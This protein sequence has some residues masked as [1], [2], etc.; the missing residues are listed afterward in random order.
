MAKVAYVIS[1]HF[2]TAGVI[3]DQWKP[4]LDGCDVYVSV[5]DYLGKWNA[6]PGVAG[7][8]CH[9]KRHVVTDAMV[10]EVFPNATVQIERYDLLEPLFDTQSRL[11]RDWQ[12]SLGWKFASFRCLSYL[13][14]YYRRQ[15]GYQLLE[16]TGKSYDV[17]VLTRP[18]VLIEHRIESCP[19]NVVLSAPNSVPDPT[20][21]LWINDIVLASEQSIAKYISTIYSRY[22][23]IFHTAKET[24]SPQSFFDPHALIKHELDVQKVSMQETIRAQITRPTEE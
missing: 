19:E 16:A 7:T 21:H 5:W 12:D 22:Q 3:K 10:L 13:S 18:D 23:L 4:I 8:V 9:D 11:V 1:G 15:Q 24:D 20:N 14:A 6:I 17:V 2:R